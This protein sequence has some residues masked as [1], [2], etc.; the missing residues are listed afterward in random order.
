MIQAAIDDPALEARISAL[1]PDGLSVFTLGGGKARGA[2]LHGTRMVNAMRANHSLGPLETMVLGRA[3]LAAGLLS[4][5]IKGGD[6]LA[7]RV[8]GDGPAEGFSVEAGADGSVRGWLFRSPIAPREA[9]EDFDSASLFGSGSLTMTRFSEGRPQPYTG[10]V[11]LKTGRLAQDLS[12]YYLESEQTRTAFALGIDFDR[13]GRALGAGAIYF[14]A[15][16]GADDEFLA[17]VEEALAGLPL[18]GRYFAAGADRRGFI[19]EA[20]HPLF[21]EIQG[22][23]S[24]AFACSCSRERFAD[25]LRS[26][27]DELLA[28]LAEKGPWPVE[29]VCHNCGSAYHFPK[30]ELEEMLKLRTRGQGGEGA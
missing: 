4:S 28:E 16:P 14:Q 11:A 6:R 23:K 10:T 20:L 13:E 24:V 22:E 5:T 15:L 29:T 2:L 18:L 30:G 17:K 21:P 12:A 25:F 27:N 19:E 9:I 1:P 3:Y 26:A 8:D 7:L